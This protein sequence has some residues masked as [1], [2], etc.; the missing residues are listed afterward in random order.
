MIC[1]LY[2]IVPAINSSVSCKDGEGMSFFSELGK[3]ILNE[4]SNSKSQLDNGRGKAAGLST[5]ELKK[6]VKDTKYSQYERAA[7]SEEL[8]RRR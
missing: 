8:K 7:Y 6:R 4:V 2:R 3:S 5:S 1:R